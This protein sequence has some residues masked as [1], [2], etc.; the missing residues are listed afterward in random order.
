MTVWCKT[1]QDAEGKKRSARLHDC[2]L[3]TAATFNHASTSSFEPLL[4]VKGVGSLL[5]CEQKLRVTEFGGDDD[6][7]SVR[8]FKMAYAGHEV[9]IQ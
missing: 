7:P 8:Q 6:A 2:P 5:S 9:L 4:C 3:K 1:C